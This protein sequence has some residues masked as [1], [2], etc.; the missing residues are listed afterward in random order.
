MDKTMPVSGRELLLTDSQSANFEVY[1]SRFM[2]GLD[3]GGS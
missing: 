1:G 2:V 3:E